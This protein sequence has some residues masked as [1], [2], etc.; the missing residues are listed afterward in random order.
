MSASR[1]GR[2]AARGG[3]TDCPLVPGVSPTP[4]LAPFALP[5]AIQRGR[6]GSG[7]VNCCFP[8][9]SIY[10]YLMKLR[11]ASINTSTAGKISIAQA[12]RC[13]LICRL[14]SN[15]CG[16]IERVETKA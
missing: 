14:Y 11:S 3:G 7:P 1:N 2:R 10:V 5:I 9:W 12:S 13:M 15:S 4:F 6:A 8:C 16:L